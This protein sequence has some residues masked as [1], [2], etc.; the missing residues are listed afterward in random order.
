MLGL[1]LV[2]SQVPS[3]P[4]HSMIL[5]FWLLCMLLLCSSALP[6]LPSKAEGLE[7]GLDLGVGLHDPPKSLPA[8]GIS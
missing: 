4:N 7:V 8:Q 6:S 3:S 1:V 5:W 2:T